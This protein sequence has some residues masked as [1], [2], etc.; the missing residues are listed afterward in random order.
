MGRPV[1]RVGRKWPTWPRPKTATAFT[2]YCSRF[3]SL[4]DVTV[5]FFAQLRLMRLRYHLSSR[6]LAAPPV[7]HAGINGS[8]YGLSVLP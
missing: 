2:T 3:V 8:A 6:I 7:S 5:F 1:A 4:A